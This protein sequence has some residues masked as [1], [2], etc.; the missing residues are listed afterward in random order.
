MKMRMLMF[1]LALCLSSTTVFG[2]DEWGD[3]TMT[4]KL[5]GPIP[6]PKPITVTQDLP[7][8]GKFKLLDETLV[9]NS[10]NSGIA[11][12]FVW[13]FLEKGVTTKVHDDYKATEKSEVTLD[14]T[15]CRFEPRAMILRTTQT[16]LVG[17]K[18]MVGHNTNIQTSVN[19]GQNNLIPGGGVMKQKFPKEERLGAPV[20]CNIHPWMKSHLLVKETPYMAVSDENGKVEIKNLPVGKWTFQVWHEKGY[21]KDIK[22]NEKLA[23]WPKGK[24]ENQVIKSGKNDLGEIKVPLKLFQ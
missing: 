12:I 8:C 4:F 3:L 24:L 15:G 16:L 18:D 22:L 10:A 1:V 5:D 19:P 2:A 23:T 11:N 13:L 7:F 9:V 14:N 21:V 17:N 20:S 6:T